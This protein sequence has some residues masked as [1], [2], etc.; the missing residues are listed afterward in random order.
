MTKIWTPSK[1]ARP[2]DLVPLE[3]VDTLLTQRSQL[4]R[5]FPNQDLVSR[6]RGTVF[7]PSFMEQAF[8]TVRD[9]SF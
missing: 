8:T 3:L 9:L 2:P 4:G 5:I 6:M 1:G 7:Y